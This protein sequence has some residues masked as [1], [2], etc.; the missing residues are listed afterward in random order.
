MN[1]K[2]MAIGAASILGLGT[3]AAGA[4]SIANAV[5][6]RN[7]DG[8]VVDVAQVRGDLLERGS[9]E[10]KT[11][12]DHASVLSAN[13]A[14]SAGAPSAT[15]S[16][17]SALAA[18]APVSANSPASAASAAPAQQQTTQD[19]APSPVHSANSPVSAQ[20]AGSNA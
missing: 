14:A 6:L 10:I 16:A 11:N 8:S 7:A 17:N 13:T 9:V 3:M 19:S 15:Q 4:T 1:T 5:E 20:S 12:G 2:W 18:T